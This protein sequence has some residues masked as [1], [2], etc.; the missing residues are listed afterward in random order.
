MHTHSQFIVYNIYASHFIPN[1]EYPNYNMLRNY[2][3]LID[4]HVNDR[5]LIT[6]K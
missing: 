1:S 6:S 2:D 3:R 4:V 5:K